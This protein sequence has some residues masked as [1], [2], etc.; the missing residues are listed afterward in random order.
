MPQL[1]PVTIPPGQEWDAKGFLD[2]VLQQ[3]VGLAAPEFQTAG[4][5]IWTGMATVMI[6][7]TGL[8]TAFSGDYDM[9][10]IVKLVVGLGIPRTMLAFYDNPV[11]G[12]TMSFPELI[13]RQG[14]W[15]TE[16]FI[17]NSWQ[18]LQQTVLP[19]FSNIFTQ[20]TDSIR[21]FGAADVWIKGV[22]FL[23]ASL[24]G[25]VFMALM[26]V[27]LLLMFCLLMAQ[28]I[29]AQFALAVAI[30]V[31]PIL[32]PWLIFPPLSFLFWGW[33][34]T[35]LTNN[36]YGVNAGADFNVFMNVGLG[37]INTLQ[38]AL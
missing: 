36:N 32:I 18:G 33:F 6:V 24:F 10:E 35:Q 14:T 37:F 12:T 22:S 34:R 15:A 30:M 31:G 9:W 29:W 28:V 20:I 27:L 11:P 38:T 17:G 23:I 7:W 8:K 3:L 1:T 4:L 5:A 21:S 26:L 25:S 13:T 19:A 2:Q 16:V